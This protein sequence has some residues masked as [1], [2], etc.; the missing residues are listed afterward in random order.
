MRV[1]STLF[2][3]FASFR[4]SARLARPIVVCLSRN[5]FHVERKGRERA[6]GSVSRPAVPCLRAPSCT[7]MFD[8]LR[9]PFVGSPPSLPPPRTLPKHRLR[10][11][12]AYG[13]MVSDTRMP[14]KEGWPLVDALGTSA[15][16]PD[17]VDHRRASL[18][19]IVHYCQ[20]RWQ[21]RRFCLKSPGR[22][23]ALVIFRAWEGVGGEG[24]HCFCRGRRYG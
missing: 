5:R 20:V 23:H 21:R 12:V 6:W 15:C 1:F 16:D 13:L 19:P 9:P 22:V 24:R 8:K 2:L 11:R 18:P 7:L 10:H 3:S 14:G 4:S 17:S